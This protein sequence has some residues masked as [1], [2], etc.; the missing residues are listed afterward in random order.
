MQYRH[1]LQQQ[2]QP[3]HPGN[4]MSMGGGPMNAGSPG[5][6]PSFNPGMPMPPG[7]P[8]QQHP[9][10]QQFGP[11]G[12][13]LSGP[14]NPKAPMGMLPPPSPAKD[15]NKDNKGPTNGLP[16]GS[17]RNQ[18][19]SNPN[20]PGTAPPTPNSSGQQQQQGQQGGGN[21]APSP[22]L[23]I[24]PNVNANA[25]NTVGMP[26]PPAPPSATENLFGTDF[27]QSVANGLDEFVD[28]G[29]FR[30]DGDLNFERDFGQWFNPDDV[31]MDLGKQ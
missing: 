17:P 29:L 2:G 12:N 7:G 30:G 3:G 23:M 1:N 25:L 9:Q 26:L 11:P 8:G 31:G 21:M 28:V 6:D 19:L 24:N 10:P 16:D 20:A 5:S 15:Q 4:R 27:I 22:G 18:P 13:R 14:P